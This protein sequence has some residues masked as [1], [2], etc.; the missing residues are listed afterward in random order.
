MPLL[1]RD[2]IIDR[3]TLIDRGSSEDEED[4]RDGE[5]VIESYGNGPVVNGIQFEAGDYPVVAASN[6]V[7]VLATAD[8]EGDAYESSF[9][10]SA[11]QLKEAA[12]AGINIRPMA[13]LSRDRGL[14]DIGLTDSDMSQLRMVTPEV[15]EP[16]PEPEVDST[17]SDEEE[18]EDDE[19]DVEE[20]V[21]NDN[22]D[23]DDEEQENQVVE[24]DS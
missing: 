14:D 10:T 17:D 19:L 12:E 23:T 9:I 11:I 16:E 4:T 13:R 7:A 1:N 18:S 24:D 20:E 5:E 22:E 2:T 15:E 6:L 3:R 21:E 8:D